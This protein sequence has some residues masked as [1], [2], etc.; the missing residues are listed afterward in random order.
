VD[1]QPFNVDGI[2]LDNIQVVQGTDE[3]II[4]TA[5]LPTGEVGTP[6][7]PEP[8]DTF[9]GDPPL[10]WSM[11][12]EFFEEVQGPLGVSGGGVAQNL[13]GDDVVM[14]YTLPFSFPFYGVDHT[15]VKIATD[16]WIN[17]GPYVGSTWNNSVASL[18]ANTRI[19]VMWDDLRTDIGTDGTAATRG[20]I[21]I[22]ESVP[23]RVTIRWDAVTRSAGNQ[24]CNFSA[25]LFDDGAIQLN[26]G[27]GNT[28]LTPTVGVSAGVDGEI[29][30]ASHDAASNL[31]D[32][33][34]LLLDFGKLPPGLSMDSNGV[35]SGVPTKGG[36]F[37]A[38]V[39]IE[40]Q[41][42]P[43]RTDSKMIPITILTNVFGDI[44]QDG[45]ADL[46]DYA[47]FAFCM[48]QPPALG[49]CVSTFD[50]NGNEIMDLEDFAAFQLA[51]TGPVN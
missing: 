42:V 8:I 48:E 49:E 1:N 26:Y 24:P 18:L 36:A 4:L 14:D 19:A 7:G 37:Q 33:N 16:G 43:P 40:D 51:F 20:D 13:H 21:Y 39:V 35:V 9:G 46:D 27:A 44:D 28:P 2:A 45:D 34:S 12:I 25:T 50:V 22:D 41:R 29:F 31:G 23:G 38:L 5:A 32:A 10:V 6:Y 47:L 15:A 30:L 3:P 17:F 11:P